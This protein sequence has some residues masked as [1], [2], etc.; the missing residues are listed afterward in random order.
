MSNNV[1]RKR[2]VPF[3]DQEIT[4]PPAAGLAAA[5]EQLDSITRHHIINELCR[6]TGATRINNGMNNTIGTLI[7]FTIQYTHIINN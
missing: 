3:R 4:R 2:R 7:V 6:T 5:D 1:C